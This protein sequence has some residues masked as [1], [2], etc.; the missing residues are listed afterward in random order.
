MPASP[1]EHVQR[2]SDLARTYP[3]LEAAFAALRAK[4]IKGVVAPQHALRY[5]ATRPPW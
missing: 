4:E 3:T 2:M 1:L 5:E